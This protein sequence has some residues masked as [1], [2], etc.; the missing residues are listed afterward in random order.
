MIFIFRPCRLL[1]SCWD[2]KREMWGRKTPHT[3]MMLIPGSDSH[4]HV[5]GGPHKRKM[6]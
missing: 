2:E 6:E 3:R 5:D 4:D 1:T